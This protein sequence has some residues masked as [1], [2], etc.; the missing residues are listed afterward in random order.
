MLQKRT[1]F[2]ITRSV[3]FALLLREIR[4]RFGAKRFGAFWLF[5][6]PVAQIALM[7]A[8][9]SLR[10]RT[11]SYGV[12]F[13]IF[14]LTGM[15]PFFAMRSIVYKVMEAVNA[16]RA[17]F[18]YKQIKPIDTMVARAVIEVMIHAGVY[19]IL[20]F[21]L[22]FWLRI[23]I[24]HY[25]PLTWLAAMLVGIVFSFALGMIFCMLTEVVPELKT[26]VRMTFFPLYLL[27][28]VLFPVQSLPPEVL[29]LLLWNPYLHIINEL[30]S[31]VFEYYPPIQGV[32]L[33]FPFICSIALLL[34]AFGLYRARRLKL[35][36]L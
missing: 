20:L 27:S 18:S 15:V 1:S 4:G 3:L 10:G 36:S 25:Q 33:T 5:F 24:I 12:E 26:V 35:V 31:S 17:L 16:N 6:E 13:P 7:M 22:G 21:V 19:V 2:K 8:V 11:V 23:D 32:N 28:G 34:V 30:R 9:F 14:L 29:D